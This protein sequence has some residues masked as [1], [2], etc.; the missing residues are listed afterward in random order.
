[1]DAG[2]VHHVRGFCLRNTTRQDTAA[3]LKLFGEA[4]ADWPLDDLRVWVR[5]GRGADYSGACY[6]R[7]GRIFINLGRHLKY[8][9]ALGTRIARAVTLPDRWVKQIYFVACA[10][11]YQLATFLWRHECYHWLVRKARRN[12]RQKESMCDRFAVR[13]L[14]DRWNCAV[15]TPEGDKV[16]RAEWDFQEVERFVSAARSKPERSMAQTSLSAHAT[17]PP[18]S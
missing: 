5:Y 2:F 17:R 12:G 10:D 14:V 1:M 15:T 6:T 18:T 7:E 8:P 11:P 16:A 9:Y 3:L 13:Y 4:M